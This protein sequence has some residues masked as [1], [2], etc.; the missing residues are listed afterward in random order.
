MAGGKSE[1]VAGFFLGGVG[2]PEVGKD[3]IASLFSEQARARF[4]REGKQQEFARVSK[5]G[6]DYAF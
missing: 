5:V 4:A 3:G 2:L 1:S 6:A